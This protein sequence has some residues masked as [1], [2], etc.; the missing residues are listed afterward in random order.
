MDFVASLILINAAAAKESRERS[1]R[2]PEEV[3]V[4]LGEEKQDRVT[5]LIKSKWHSINRVFRELSQQFSALFGGKL[6][7][8]YLQMER[9][10]TCQGE[11][12]RIAGAAG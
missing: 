7:C 2:M 8:Y 4:G 12:S 10:P 5:V 3:S 11:S 6:N 1:E 9:M